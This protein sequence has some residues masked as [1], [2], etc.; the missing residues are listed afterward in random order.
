MSD[1]PVLQ[2]QDG[3]LCTKSCRT[4]SKGPPRPESP[5]SGRLRENLADFGE[6]RKMESIILYQEVTCD[7]CIY[8]ILAR[9]HE[10]CLLEIGQ[11][12][13]QTL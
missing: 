10:L 12:S 7:R 13:Q 1:E 8:T 11:V 6:G 5:G 2:L 3:R 4:F 9:I